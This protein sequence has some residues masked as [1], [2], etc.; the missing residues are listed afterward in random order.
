[1]MNDTQTAID[2]RSGEGPSVQLGAV[3]R[4][5]Q[6]C[7]G[8]LFVPGTDKNAYVYKLECTLCGLSYGANSGDVFQRK[9]P[10]CQGGAPGIRYWLIGAKGFRRQRS[11]RR[12]GR[13]R[14]NRECGGLVE[15]TSA[16]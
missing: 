6:R 2:F 9:C 7:L 15:R 1:M 10:N 14:H 5:G 8:T 13:I 3:N 16:R 4:N 12:T 11:L